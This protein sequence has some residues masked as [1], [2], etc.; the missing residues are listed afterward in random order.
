MNKLL[1]KAKQ[2]KVKK[3]KYGFTK[4][5]FE[6]AY[7]VIIGNLTEGQF[8]YGAGIK[9]DAGSLIS[10]N[11]GDIDPYTRPKTHKEIAQALRSYPW[12]VE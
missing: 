4:D 11:D 6:L 9:R 7:N 2:K 8:G 12:K 10:H 5:H 1:E 3:S